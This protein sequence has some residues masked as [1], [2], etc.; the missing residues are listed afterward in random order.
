MPVDFVIEIIWTFLKPRKR[1]SKFL[2]YVT[3]VSTEGI[4]L[5]SES[6]E[7]SEQ[8]LYVAIADLGYFGLNPLGPELQE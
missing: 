6:G 3:N 1:T 4:T 2:E 5:P 8:C 7:I